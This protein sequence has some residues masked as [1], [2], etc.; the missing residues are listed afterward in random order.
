MV[1]FGARRSNVR[2]IH[3]HGAFAFAI[4]HHF[5]QGT[6]GCTDN[7]G[8]SAVAVTATQSSPIE[9]SRSEQSAVSGRNA[10]ES[11]VQKS[12]VLEVLVPFSCCCGPSSGPCGCGV[13]L[14][15]QEKEG[16]Q[17]FNAQ[18]CRCRRLVSNQHIGR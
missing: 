16:A 14:A 18:G 4:R 17:A 6:V 2:A 11:F 15:L 9:Q 10:I 3:L 1:L 12:S 7:H 8:G 5:V 13:R